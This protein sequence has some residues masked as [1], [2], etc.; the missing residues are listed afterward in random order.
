MT[1]NQLKFIQRIHLSLPN[2][3]ETVTSETGPQAGVERDMN[4]NKLFKKVTSSQSST[5]R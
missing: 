3:V 4:Q 2:Q 1:Y 5:Q